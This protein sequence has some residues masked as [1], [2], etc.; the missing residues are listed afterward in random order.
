MM[1]S[2]QWIIERF[3][4]RGVPLIGNL[5]AAA[6]QSMHALGVAEHQSEI[7]EVARRYEADGKPEIAASVPRRA[8]QIGSVP[9][10]D[11]AVQ[12]AKHVAQPL[13]SLLAGD[14]KESTKLSALPS[15]S[16][17]KAKRKP[18]TVQPIDPLDFQDNRSS[19]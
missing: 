18:R 13:Q 5:F 4:E 17:P 6:I 19:D 1:K 2:M 14:D 11:E 3:V 7:E 15:P 9:S 16:K 10:A 12:I 8:E